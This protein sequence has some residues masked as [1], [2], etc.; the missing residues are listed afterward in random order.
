MEIEILPVNKKTLDRYC[1]IPSYFEV[2]SILEVEVLA[3][4]FKGMK[5]KEKKVARPYTKNYD[6]EGE[7][8]SWLNF[9][10]SNWVAFL[11]SEGESLVGGLTVACRTPELRMLNG[12]DD[13]ADVWDIR[14]HPD[15]KRKGFGARLFQEAVA[16]SRNKGFK[17]LC[18]E[19]QNVNVR[20]CRFY[21]KQGCRL[22][23]INRFAYYS[24]PK[25]RDEV[26]FIWFMDL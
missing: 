12:R 14:V 22:G 21:L 26:Q 24:S 20:A 5:F 15:Y 23:A 6:T 10:T 9:N 13:L 8:F 16:W 1:V 17:Q 2:N 11:V 25:E 19:T 7:P 18:V 4:G 3:D